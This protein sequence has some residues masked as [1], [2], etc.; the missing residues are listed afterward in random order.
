MQY[1]RSIGSLFL[2]FHFMPSSTD[3]SPNDSTNDLQQTTSGMPQGWE[4]REDGNGRT[5]YINH[6]LRTTQFTPPESIPKLV[7]PPETLNF[8]YL[9]SF[10]SHRKL[11][12]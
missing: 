10:F 6:A 3:N 12:L 9:L 11:D 2:S 7:F 8:L 4:E 5:V 1:F